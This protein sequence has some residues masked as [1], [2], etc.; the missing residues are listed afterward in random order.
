MV[1]YTVSRLLRQTVARLS[2]RD[3]WEKRRFARLVADHV[4]D[5]TEVPVGGWCGHSP[6]LNV[7]GFGQQDTKKKVELYRNLDLTNDSTQLTLLQMCYVPVSSFR[8]DSSFHII[9]I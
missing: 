4:S 6:T 7:V 2:P 5:L 9:S 3:A 1:C 8:T